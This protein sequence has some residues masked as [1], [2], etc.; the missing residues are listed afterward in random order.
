MVLARRS[1]RGVASAARS[2]RAAPI[3]RR[4]GQVLGRR[5]YSSEKGE[6]GFEDH[7][8]SDMPWYVQLDQLYNLGLH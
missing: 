7:S 5:F 1:L 3:A 2:F 6:K 8:T 4:S